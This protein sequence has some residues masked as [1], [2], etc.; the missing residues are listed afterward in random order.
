AQMHVFK[1]SPRKGTPAATMENQ[2]DPQ[3]KQLRSEKL[4]SL[5]K[6]NFEKFASKFIDKNLPVLFEKKIDENHYEGLTPNYIRVLVKSDFDIEGKIL[7]VKITKSK[8]EYIEG[9]LI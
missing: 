2:I 1:Y 3:I 5:S 7:N 8:D 6:S 4:I 9:N